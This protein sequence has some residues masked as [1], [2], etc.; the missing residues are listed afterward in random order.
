MIVW[1]PRAAAINYHVDKHQKFLDESLDRGRR[2]RRGRRARQLETS[3]TLTPEQRAAKHQ[4]LMDD[5]LRS[6]QQANPK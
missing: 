5:I 6:I 4:Q 3:T 2:G 1:R